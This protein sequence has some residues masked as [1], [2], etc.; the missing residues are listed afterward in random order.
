MFK[1]TFLFILIIKFFEKIWL[2][3]A[4]QCA[5]CGY[6]IHIK[7]YEKTIGKTICG[8]FF[9]KLNNDN[10]NLQSGSSSDKNNNNDDSYVVIPDE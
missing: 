1:I 2:K 8:R 5:Y 6:V 9:S 3:N 10:S 7:C 4:Y